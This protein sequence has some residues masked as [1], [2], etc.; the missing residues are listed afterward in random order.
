ME[1]RESLVNKEDFANS[2]EYLRGLFSL[3]MSGFHR[4][5][6]SSNFNITNLRYYTKDARRIIYLIATFLLLNVLDLYTTYQAL[7]SGHAT[8]ANPFMARF[9]DVPELAITLKIAGVY[10]AI[11]VVEKLAAGNI[12]LALRSILIVNIVQAVI[13][14]NNIRFCI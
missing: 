6:V 7:A 2:S 8:E 3:D 13:C 9:L 5:K 1:Q 12:R 14:A 4:A 11:K 10:I